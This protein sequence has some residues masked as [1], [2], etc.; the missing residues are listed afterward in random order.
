MYFLFVSPEMSVDVNDNLNFKESDPYGDFNSASSYVNTKNTSSDI[1]ESSLHCTMLDLDK[2]RIGDDEIVGKAT[3][4]NQD[5]HSNAKRVGKLLASNGNSPRPRY[6]I[7][8][9]I[10]CAT[11]K[12]QNFFFHSPVIVSL[13]V[14]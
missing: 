10:V 9:Y 3:L 6:I 12:I 11:F 13:E 7:L 2:L 1:C 4:G 8:I 14:L 5:P